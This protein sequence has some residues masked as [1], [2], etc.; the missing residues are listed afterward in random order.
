MYTNHGSRLKAPNRGFEHYFSRLTACLA[1]AFAAPAFSQ[2][3]DDTIV[4]P[5]LY[6]SMTQASSQTL[7]PACWQVLVSERELLIRENNQRPWLMQNIMPLTGAALGGL[8]AGLLL[9]RHATIAIAKRWALPVIAGG[10]AAGFLLGPGGVAGAVLGGAIGNQ[11][12]KP[13]VAPTLAG[14]MA[15][16]LVGKGVWEMVFPP[17]V[18]PPPSDD[19]EDDIPVEVFLKDQSCGTRIEATHSQSLYRVAYSFKGEERLAELP[20][21]PGEAL[22][23]SADG[24]IA[25]PARR[26]ID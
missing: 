10:G 20:Y 3:A 25:G 6:A 1:L 21:D 17:A 8:S 12:G 4:A 13:K 23:V 26:R 7:V 16:A 5:V 24:E 18:P 22:L 15:G 19:P 11:L 14:A 9:R 2:D